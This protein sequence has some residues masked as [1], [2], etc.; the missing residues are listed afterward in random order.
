MVVVKIRV[1][2][3]VW[4]MPDDRVR[5]TLPDAHS[6]TRVCSSLS[7]SLSLS[8]FLSLCVCVPVVS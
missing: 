8:L 1:V 4:N 6:S 5:C 3:S 2:C 7:L